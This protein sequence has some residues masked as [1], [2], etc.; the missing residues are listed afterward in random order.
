MT[1]LTQKYFNRLKNLRMM[2]S[3]S[4]L[5]DVSFN[6]SQLLFSEYML[7]RILKKPSDEEIAV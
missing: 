2:R 3:I 6:N 7:T 1:E 5:N 4:K